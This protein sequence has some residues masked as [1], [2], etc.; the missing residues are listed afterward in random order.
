MI[1]HYKWSVGRGRY[2]WKWTSLWLQAETLQLISQKYGKHKYLE[3]KK[4]EQWENKINNEKPND[5]APPHFLSNRC[6]LFSSINLTSVYRSYLTKH[7]AICTK[8]SVRKISDPT[9]NVESWL[10]TL[11]K[12]LSTCTQLRISPLQIRC[13][14]SKQYN[15]EML[16]QQWSFL[17]RHIHH[18]EFST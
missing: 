4:I 12:I 2:L 7:F 9:I 6:H 3:V 10:K 16:S 8:I 11:P 5:H 1:S 15:R 14:H 18:F 17:S 13:I